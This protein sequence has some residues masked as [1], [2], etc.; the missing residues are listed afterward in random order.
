MSH[1]PVRIVHQALSLKAGGIYVVDENEK[2]GGN[3][4]V[5]TNFSTGWAC[6]MKERIFR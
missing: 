5:I 1:S 2:T 4:R 3:I 6:G